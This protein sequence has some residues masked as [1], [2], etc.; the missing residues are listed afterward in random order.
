MYLFY[1]VMH[2][3]SWM[4]VNIR[5]HDKSQT[6]GISWLTSLENSYGL[7]LKNLNEISYIYIYMYIF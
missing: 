2:N 1:L 5:K 7:V 6:L 4:Q 3:E